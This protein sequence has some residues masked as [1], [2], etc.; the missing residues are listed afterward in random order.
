MSSI[1][2]PYSAEARQ[3]VWTGIAGKTSEGPSRQNRK[4][5][6]KILSTP[7]DGEKIYVEGM[8]I[9]WSTVS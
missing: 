8:K 5:V 1:S 6:K 7:L 4:D 9:P 3:A 2:N